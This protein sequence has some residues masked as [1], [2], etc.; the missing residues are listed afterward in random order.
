[1]WKRVS[2]SPP[3]LDGGANPPIPTT[4]WQL[5]QATRITR[6]PP[7]R[8]DAASVVSTSRMGA[9]QCGQSGVSGTVASPGEKEPGTPTAWVG[10]ALRRTAG[11]ADEHVRQ[12]LLASRA[13]ARRCLMRALG[14]VLSAEPVK[15]LYLSG[16]QSRLPQ[17]AYPL[18]TR[19][20]K[21][22][23]PSS[24]SACPSACGARELR[25]ISGG[26]SE[27]KGMSANTGITLEGNPR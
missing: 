24:P 19:V 12:K 7:R 21:S 27:W 23:P 5:G 2:L 22:P 25:K 26:P 13:T 15:T 18:A 1:M 17:A 9:S 11:P 20:A 6:K 4:L 10:L 8:E 16:S 3:P 14:R